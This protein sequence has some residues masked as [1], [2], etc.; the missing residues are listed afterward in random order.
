MPI[1]DSCDESSFVVA[2]V[3]E[4]EDDTDFTCLLTTVEFGS[5]DSNDLSLSSLVVWSTSNWL[6]ALH[7]QK[8]CSHLQRSGRCH[9]SNW[10]LHR[11]R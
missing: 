10:V 7:P 9:R 11:C 2:V 4:V 1:Y 3:E 8:E 5:E 6:F